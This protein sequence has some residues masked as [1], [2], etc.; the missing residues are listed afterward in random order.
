MNPSAMSESDAEQALRRLG[1]DPEEIRT[2]LKEMLRD[3]GLLGPATKDLAVLA[4]PGYLA[5]VSLIPLALLRNIPAMLAAVDHRRP[6]VRAWLTFSLTSSMIKTARQAHRVSEAESTEGKIQVTLKR[7]KRGNNWNEAVP[8]SAFLAIT[9]ALG[10]TR[11]H[12]WQTAWLL[13]LLNG[14]AHFGAVWFAA[15]RPDE[16]RA[17]LEV[18]YAAEAAKKSAGTAEEKLVPE[19]APEGQY[20]LRRDPLYS[21][22]RAET[23]RRADL[24]PESPP[25]EKTPLKGGNLPS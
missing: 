14:A 23:Y 13:G 12:R 25:D 3:Q 15:R 17:A 22:E 10:Y 6:G 5:L 19:E 8:D 20:G 2:S 4:K 18:L 7:L 11:K 21:D 1:I 9:A 16:I 24:D